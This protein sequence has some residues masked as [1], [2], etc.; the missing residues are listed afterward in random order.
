MP[1]Y[2]IEREILG[3]GTLSAQELQAISQRFC[4]VVSQMGAEIQ[5]VESYVTG[6][7]LYCTYIA[8]NEELI[9]EHAC[10]GG[11]PADRIEEIWAVIDPTTAEGKGVFQPGR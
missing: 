1:K 9:Q 5:W 6:D 8:A 11:F 3:A 10:R 7:R 4:S 2:M